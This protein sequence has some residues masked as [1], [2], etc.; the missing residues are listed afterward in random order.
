MEVVRSEEKWNIYQLDDGAELR[1]RTVV[2]EIWR[3]I[4]V[5]DAEGNPQ[6]VVRAQGATTVNAP[7]NIR[8]RK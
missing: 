5:Y 4:D 2:M 6:Y 1:M 8:K 7:E 3:L